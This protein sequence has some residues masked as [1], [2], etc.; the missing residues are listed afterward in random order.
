MMCATTTRA[1]PFDACALDGVDVANSTFL[2]VSSKDKSYRLILAY[3]ANHLASTS[4]HRSFEVRTGKKKT[5]RSNLDDSSDG[6]EGASI[7]LAGFGLHTFTWQYHTLQCLRQS[8]GKPVGTYQN[9]VRFENIVLVTRHLNAE[10]TLHSFVDA[11]VAAAEATSNGFFSIYRWS[12]CDGSWTE[13]QTHQRRPLD[14]VVLPRQMKESLID[15]VE[16]FLTDN[17]RAFYAAHGIPYK[18]G[19]LFHGVPGSGKTSL[20][21]AIATHCNRNVCMLQITHPN[22]NDTYLRS[23]LDEL[24]PRSVLVLEDID[25]AFTRDRKPKMENSGLT[26]S[27]LL[28][29]LDGL[30][31]QDGHILVMTT[32]FRHQL[33]D[34]LIRNG[35]ID[36]QV[37]FSYTTSDQ[38][39]DMFLQFYP[40]ET[41]ERGRD[42]A[43]ALVT[44]LC[45]D[46]RLTT[47]R[48]QHYFVTHRRSTA[49][50]AIANVG[51]WPKRW[52]F[53]EAG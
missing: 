21:Q 9:V 31:F 49:D 52:M 43:T 22:L 3:V 20:I 25:A 34:A 47:A 41:R 6:E 37:E 19:Y 10:T 39:A 53:A 8:V 17:C 33:D 11:V 4:D 50:E 28:N 18:R 45:P 5:Q 42:F 27:G 13:V 24:P 16:D 2:R 46:R 7:V 29:A 35:R 30:E 36:V 14:S 38:M 32:N 15:D 1:I 23:I 12:F 26:F 40:S 44:A 48:L 51:A